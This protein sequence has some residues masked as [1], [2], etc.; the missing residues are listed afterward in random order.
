[1]ED[2]LSPNTEIK[3][4]PEI[5]TESGLAIASKLFTY[6]DTY[7]EWCF[8]RDVTPWVPQNAHQ[9]GVADINRALTKYCE[10]VGTTPGDEGF[11]LWVDDMR[12]PPWVNDPNPH[13]GDMIPV[14]YPRGE[15]D[16]PGLYLEAY[17]QG[18]FV[19]TGYRIMLAQT[20][21]RGG[22]YIPRPGAGFHGPH[23]QRRFVY[24]GNV[25]YPV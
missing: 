23:P 14:E 5:R 8:T 16:D 10:L 15:D 22:N 19:W 20:V 21:W 3:F 18:F 12:S 9:P 4:W 24:P 6:W 11:P 2:S 17:K 13:G 7:V 1:M 25:D